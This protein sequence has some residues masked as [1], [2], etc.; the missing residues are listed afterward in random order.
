MRGDANI[1]ELRLCMA[2]AVSCA[3]LHLATLVTIVPFFTIA[4]PGFMIVS[5]AI[6]ARADQ[7]QGGYPMPSGA[8]GFLGILL[9]CYAMLTAVL[10]WK[11]TGAP[12]G[13]GIVDGQYVAKF[14]YNITKPITAQEY[15]MIPNGWVRVLSALLGSLAVFG[16]AR[17]REMQKGGRKAWTRHHWRGDDW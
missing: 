14:K 11:D 3:I 16:W 5:V 9:F 8:L 12:I 15:R 1:G 6:S 7:P 2:T 10:F 13:V 17:N 4:V